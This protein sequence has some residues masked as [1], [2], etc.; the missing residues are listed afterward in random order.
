MPLLP[1]LAGFAWQPRSPSTRLN[2]NGDSVAIVVG[3]DHKVGHDAC[4]FSHEPGIFE[5]SAF[6]YFFYP[7]ELPGETAAI[8]LFPCTAPSINTM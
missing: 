8:A 6:H 1:R 3:Q 4:R 2:A 7:V 5:F